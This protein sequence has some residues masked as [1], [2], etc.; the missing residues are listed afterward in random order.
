MAYQT[1][2]TIASVVE[3]IHR[4]EYLSKQKLASILALEYVNVLS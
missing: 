4:K 3:K 2:L 1:G